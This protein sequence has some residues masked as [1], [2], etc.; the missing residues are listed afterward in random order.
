MEEEVGL[1]ERMG[2]SDK[3]LECQD[4]EFGFG[5]WEKGNHSRYGAGEGQGQTGIWPWA[6]GILGAFSSYWG[7]SEVGVWRSRRW[8]QLAPGQKFN[9]F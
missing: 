4:K 6:P 8:F 3:G 2:P 9:L 1:E 7:L 5:L